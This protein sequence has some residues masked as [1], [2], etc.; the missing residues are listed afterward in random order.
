MTFL[1][2]FITSFTPR[3]AASASFR[4]VSAYVTL[5]PAFKTTFTS[6]LAAA[7]SIRAISTHVA[8]FATF[9]AC[10]TRGWFKTISA[11]SYS[12]TTHLI[13][14]IWLL[15]WALAKSFIRIVR[16]LAPT[17]RK[18]LF[19]LFRSVF[20]AIWLVYLWVLIVFIF[21]PVICGYFWL[22]VVIPNDIFIRL[23]RPPNL[24]WYLTLIWEFWRSFFLLFVPYVETR[25]R[26]SFH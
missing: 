24:V 2:A 17:S 4:T 25:K 15:W 22:R 6:K 14:W 10:T 20:P 7:F 1:S 21:L 23:G 18:N 26:V 3:L 8:I 5:L 12:S 19:K 13:I 16:N 11:T 9:K